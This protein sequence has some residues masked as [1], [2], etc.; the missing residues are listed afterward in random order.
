[1][2]KH[3]LTWQEWD[4]FLG[5]IVTHRTELLEEADAFGHDKDQLQSIA[6]NIEIWI[7]S[8]EPEMP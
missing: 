3:S 2:E 8:H 6:E 1:M 4:I 5:F 7:R